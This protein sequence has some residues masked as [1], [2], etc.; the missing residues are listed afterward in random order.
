MANIRFIKKD[1]LATITLSKTSLNILG[2]D[3]LE[4][5]T[6]IINEIKTIPNVK[7]IAIES[8]QKVFSAGVDISEH[9]PEKVH[10]ML[11]AFHNVFFSM[12]ELEIP[13]ISLVKGGCIG[14]GCELALFSDFVLASD[15]AYFSQP[16][17]KV[18]CYPPVSL[19]YFPY[20]MPNKKAL[21]M[22]L[23]GNKLTARHA[24][25]LGII[26]QV[27]SKENFDQEAEKFINSMLTNSLSVMKTTLNAYKKIHYCEL[28]SKLAASEKIYLDEL[29]QLEDLK[30]G[31]TS[32]IE[33]R[34]A[35]WKN[36]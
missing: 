11:K 12:L 5:L 26:N 8:D 29:I 21:E 1:F 25:D 3:D 6:A 28:K 7:L 24:Y 27:F 4:Q 19:A 13:T 22:I 15:D 36:K 35:V 20:I 34:P 2:I 23:T 18:G 14:G 31:L 32:F 16:E 10:Q 30:E 33:K 9:K 17:I